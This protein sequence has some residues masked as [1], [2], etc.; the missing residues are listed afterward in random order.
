MKLNG[1]FICLLFNLFSNLQTDS[2]KTIYAIIHK[3]ENAE[4][5]SVKEVSLLLQSYENSCWINNV[6]LSESRSNAMIYLFADK[7]NLKQLIRAVDNN[8]DYM[9]YVL[10]EIIHPISDKF[11]RNGLINNLAKIRGYKKTKEKL[12]IAFKKKSST[13][14]KILKN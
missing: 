1:L 9:D 5:L 13:I 8:S 10:K 3:A 2:L 6:E 11:D 7:Y 4:R 12:L 14:L